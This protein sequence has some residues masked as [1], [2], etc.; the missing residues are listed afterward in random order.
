MEHQSAMSSLRPPK[1]LLTLTEIKFSAN[2]DWEMV[3]QMRA[4]DYFTGT[5]SQI[6]GIVTARGFGMAGMA[7][8]RGHY[9]LA[10]ATAL[11]ALNDALVRH[12]EQFDN[13]HD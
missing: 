12:P 9:G 6:T 4:D 13:A 1:G 11:R 3:T 8:E 5:V 2:R 7:I 10:C